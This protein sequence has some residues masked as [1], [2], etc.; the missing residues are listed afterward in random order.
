MYDVEDSAKFSLTRSDMSVPT[1]V[2]MEGKGNSEEDLMTQ[3]SLDGDT[4][5]YIRVTANNIIKTYD[6]DGK[7]TVIVK[8]YPMVKCT[9][10]LF[11]TDYEKKFYKQRVDGSYYF[12]AEDDDIYLQGTRE[13]AL[14]KKDH[15]FIIYEVKRCTQI[16]ESSLLDP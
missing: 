11:R 14:F 1:V 10:K 16:K 15:A 13:N 2:L 4:R 5:K 8:K 3:L 6:E 7:E 12:C 9:T